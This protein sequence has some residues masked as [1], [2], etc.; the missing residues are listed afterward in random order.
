MNSSYQYC[1]QDEFERFVG[2]ADSVDLDECGT[3]NV[4][5][6]CLVDPSFYSSVSWALRKLQDAKLVIDQFGFELDGSAVPRGNETVDEQ[7]RLSDKLT[8]LVND[9]GIAMKR[10]GYALYGGKVYKKCDKAKYTY[11]YKCEV[12]AFVNSLAANESFKARLLKDMKRVIDILANPHCEVIRPL[13]VDY[14]LIEVNDG[15]CWSIKERRFLEDAIEDKDIGHVTPRAFSPYDATREPEPKYFKEILENSL[16]E[17]EIEEFC[18]DFLRLLNHNQKRHKDKVPCLIGAANSGKTSLFQPILGLVHH[19]NIATITKQRV[20]NK[21][22]INHFTEVIFVDEA[23]PST[24]D[25]DDWKILTQGG[26][27]ACDI[28]Y[29]TAKSFI[30]RCPMLLTAQQKLEFSPEDQAAMDRRLRNYVFKSL[31]NPRKKAAEWLRRHAMDCVVWAS[32]KARPTTDQEESSDS[33]LEEE[34]V[35]DGVLKDEE[36]DALRTLPLADVW[37]DALDETGETATTAEDGSNDTTDSDDDQCIRNLRRTLALSS[38]GSLRHRQIASML[39]TRV[40]EKE[41]EKRRKHQ[42]HNARKSFLRE[43]GVS[44]EVAELLPE[45]PDAAMPS[46][47]QRQLQEYC[48]EREARQEQERREKAR[49]AFEGTWLRATEV[50]LKNCCDK[51]QSSSDPTVRLNV[52]EWMKVLCNKLKMHHESLGTFNTAEAVQERI[53]VCTALGLLREEQHHLV[54]SVAERLPVLTVSSSETEGVQQH[55]CS[56]VDE[57]DEEQSIF[58]TQQH[59]CS[60]VDETSEEQSIFITPLPSTSG[61][62]R[63]HSSFDDCAVSAALLRAS[64]TNNKKRKRQSSSQRVVKKSQNVLTRYFTSQK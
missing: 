28:K 55:T 53:K 6:I 52:K 31:P 58:I 38:T 15:K 16:T 60:E 2:D 35:G 27:T 29:Q 4:V 40:R 49:R 1:F 42:Q 30:N 36:K 5:R 9:I 25:I 3:E 56:G 50:E 63:P 37:T 61:A 24:L 44:S 26:Y 41:E 62:S 47:I 45:D 32:T 46:Q 23:S 51:Y 43:R 34:Q 64:T 33:S 39:H 54:T 14:N 21:A 22:M 13:C 48:H 57:T 18:E 12:E 7:A 10:L 20:F 59:T 19:G 11:S 17:A 8:V